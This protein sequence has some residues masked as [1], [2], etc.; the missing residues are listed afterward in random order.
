M[1]YVGIDVHASESQICT[2]TEPG[3]ILERRV[4]TRT[5]YSGGIQGGKKVKALVQAHRNGY[6]YALDRTNGKFLYAKPFCE[7]TWGKVNPDGTI[8]VND[9]ILGAVLQFGHHCAGPP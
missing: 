9:D 7:I 8:T 3:E 2:L 1:E 5:N 4:R 6:F